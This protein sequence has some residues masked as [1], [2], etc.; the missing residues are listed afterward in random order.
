[1]GADNVG[2]YIVFFE[3]NRTNLWQITAIELVLLA[4]WCANMT[5]IPGGKS[6]SFKEVSGCGLTIVRICPL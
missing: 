6:L 2:V 4:L 5:S 1:M 3:F